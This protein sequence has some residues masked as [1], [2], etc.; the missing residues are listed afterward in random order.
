MVP[1]WGGA[2]VS[3][4]T[5]V[6]SGY[7]LM[8]MWS[9]DSALGFWST[10]WGSW[11]GAFVSALPDLHPTMLTWHWPWPWLPPTG[12]G[13]WGGGTGGPS[14]PSRAP[15]LPRELWVYVHKFSADVWVLIYAFFSSWRRCSRSWRTEIKI[16]ILQVQ[17]YCTYS[18]TTSL[19]GAPLILEEWN[20]SGN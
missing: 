8:R 1:Q 18:F 13:P 19:Q 15:F 12:T 20:S 5:G 17:I 16:C 3:G 9:R 6:A 7:H 10:R 2:R 14:D 4:R 11:G